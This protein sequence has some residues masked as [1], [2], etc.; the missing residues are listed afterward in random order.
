MKYIL[1]SWCFVDKKLLFLT[2]MIAFFGV[3]MVTSSSIDYADLHYKSPYYFGLRQFIYVL[4]A[5]FAAL[6]VFCVPSSHWFRFGWL[7]LV[8]AFGLL[9]AV[10]IPGIGKEVNGSRRWIP[11]GLVNIQASEL[12]KLFIL[13]YMAGYLVRRRDEVKYRWRGFLKPMLVLVLAII[14]LLAEPDFGS[15]VVLIFAV[16]G[17]IFLAGLGLQ[18]LV[19]LGFVSIASVAAMA[20]SSSYRLERLQCFLDPWQLENRYD[21]GYQ[22]TQSLIAFGR[23]EWFGLGLGNSIQKQ[24]YLPEAHTDFVF[25]IVAEEWGFIGGTILLTFFAFWVS[26]FFLLAKKAETNAQLFQ[27]YLLYGFSL[28]LAAQIFI[29]IGVNIGLLPTKGLTLPL[30]SYGGSSLIAVFIMVGIALKVGVEEIKSAR[31]LHKLRGVN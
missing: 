28:I 10:L 18:Q 22:L 6:M 1:Q 12:A 11:L 17:M 24:F 26:Q 25:A 7:Y 13:I 29:N 21:C 8:L 19:A 5:F 16:L 30:L 2:L 15:A 31:S 20:M 23:G 4:I 27:A 14:C 3:I 9:V